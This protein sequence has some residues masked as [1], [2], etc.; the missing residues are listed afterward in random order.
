MCTS[1]S[2]WPSPVVSTITTFARPSPSVSIST[3]PRTKFGMPLPVVS[4]TSALSPASVRP[5]PFT[6]AISA[7]VRPSPLVS[8][9]TNATVT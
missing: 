6:S 9:G 4:S 1:V 8:T 7:S 3:P 5:S 2:A